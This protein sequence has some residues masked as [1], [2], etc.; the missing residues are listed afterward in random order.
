MIPE[1]LLPFL[2][3]SLLLALTPGPDIFY[4]L[5]RSLAEGTR[6]G[7]VAATGFA[8]GNIVHTLLIATGLAALLAAN[9]QLLGVVRYVGVLYLI[10]VAVRMM[11]RAAPLRPDADRGKGDGAVFR[12]SFVANVL[13]PKVLL[14][15]VGLFPQFI[16]SRE[17]AFAQTLVLGAGFIGVTLLA[18]GTVAVL[19][20]S[21]AAGLARDAR[22][23]V[24]FQQLGGLALLGV[25]VW[26]AMSPLPVAPLQ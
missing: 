4:V 20:G 25:A 5:T 18:F 19:A 23:Q 3:I 1:Q 7:L 10:Y 12:Q 9:P 16:S 22:R 21:L 13:N 2:G 26:L 24:L 17:Q 15:F 6:A 11:K 14:F 8:L